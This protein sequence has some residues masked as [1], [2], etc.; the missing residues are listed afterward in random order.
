VGQSQCACGKSKS[1]L[2][3]KNFGGKKLGKKLS[4]GTTGVQVSAP[5]G[6]EKNGKKIHGKAASDSLR[7]GPA[8]A[9][10]EK[11]ERPNKPRGFILP[12]SCEPKG[13]SSVDG[14]P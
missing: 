4:P 10:M 6:G 2:E 14:N 5:R 13:R 12:K 8:K 3:N 1:S 7:K 9:R 11:E